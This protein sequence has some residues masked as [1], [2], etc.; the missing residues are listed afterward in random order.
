MISGPAARVP[1]AT[2][3][4]Q[5][6]HRFTFADAL[7]LA[8]YLAALGISDLYASPYLQA[9]PGSMHGYDIVNHGAL[10]PEIGSDAEHAA[11]SA[12][13]KEHGM[14]QLLDIVPNHM[15]IAGGANPWW[16]DVLA[17]GPSARHARFFDIEWRPLQPELAGKVLLPV[18]GD[19]FGAVLE[20]GELTLHYAKGDFWIEYFE[21]R[22]PTAPRSRVAV[23]HAALAVL[24]LVPDH[25]ARLELESIATALD[26]LPTRKHADEAS[27]AER[28]RE[29]L[30]SRRRLREL[31]AGSEPVREAIERAVR[32][33][34]GHIGEPASFDRLE[35]L[36]DD[37]AYRLAYW[38]VAA[39]EINYRR[40]FDVN[41]LAGLRT[42]LPEVFDATHGLILRLVAEG[43][44]TG[45]RVD[46]PDGL[47]DPT[48]YL[49]RLQQAASE[50]ARAAPV[51]LVVEKILTSDEPL[52]DDWP[53]AGTVGYDFLNRV[54]ALFVD[55]AN[56]AAM[57]AV[58]RRFV[59]R[60][61]DFSELAY[62]T[63]KLILRVA[64]A[65]ELSVLAH[66]LSRLAAQ[67]RRSRDF[68][69]GSLHDALRETIACFGVYRT[70]IDAEHGEVS[71]RDRQYVERAIR[72][73]KRRNRSTSRS[74]YDFVRDALLLRWPEGLDADA[75]AEHVDFVMKF[76]QLTGPVM[77]KG[78]E[79]TAFYRFDR[80]VSLNEVGGDPSAFGIAPA[81]FHAWVA[82]RAERW[83]HTMNATSTHDTK[84]SEDVRA[85]ID[86]LSEIPE[87]WAECVARW[88][89]WNAP[90]KRREG[91]LP[92]PDAND[93][94]LLY[95]TLVGAWPLGAMDGEAYAGF[96]LR[97]QQYMQKAMREAKLHTS[98]IDEDE[99]YEAGVRDFIAAILEPGEDNRFLAD[100][101][102][103]QLAISR[104]GMVN[105]LAQLLLKLAC[106]GVPDLYQGQE[107]WDFSLVDPDNRRPVD[108]ARRQRLLRELRE[109][110]A[111]EDRAALARELVERWEDGRIKLYVTHLAL[112]ARR[113]EPALFAEGDYVPLEARGARAAHCIAF[114]RTL[115]GR[116]VVVAVPRLVAALCRGE[117]LELP[118]AAAWGDTAV[119]GAPLGSRWRDVFTGREVEAAEGRIELGPLFGAF[120]VVLLERVPK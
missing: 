45:L 14:G 120:P 77:A 48:A 47:F 28:R 66:L 107:L 95:Q 97:I 80:L 22:F 26:N 63:K 20:R 87:R 100:F 18:L 113:A 112:E 92:V 11:L 78:V 51:Y 32:D 118:D 60:V 109:R 43:K 41:D 7:E 21:H 115:G 10:N 96:T 40:F 35:A 2:Y 86:V 116:S 52:R 110:L 71:E 117:A 56:E 104:P 93:E 12:A 102:A 24:S 101:V 74:I 61:P 6:N 69:P 4:L 44:I 99:E 119:A 108:F 75:R 55:P 105:S 106:P 8:P 19:Q 13:L 33:L 76:Q 73:A 57:D 36:L 37:Q 62:R 54:N 15:G 79:D 114:A 38:R 83:P 31:T 9:R 3:R 30:V 67:S 29:D 98:W 65:S 94:Y 17:N 27:T 42:E 85:R 5:F 84:R 81:D 39:E 103:F 88:A 111:R 25:P 16:Q 91:E 82:R 34:N 64:L 90:T 50:R 58:Y 49:Q 1:R 53:V 68:T 23:L 46:H 59:P 70:Y 89:E 72:E